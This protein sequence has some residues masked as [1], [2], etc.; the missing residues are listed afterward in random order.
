M[1]ES[2]QLFYLRC[3]CLSFNIHKKRDNKGGGGGGLFLNNMKI[4][5]QRME[6]LETCRVL[7][8]N[9]FWIRSYSSPVYDKRLSLTPLKGAF[10]ML[11]K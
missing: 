9:K 11:K 7:L 1:H 10:I 2:L 3:A 8:Y 6:F 4:S 5:T